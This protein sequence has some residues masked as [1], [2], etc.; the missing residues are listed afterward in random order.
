MKKLKNLTFACL[1]ILGL[2]ACAGDDK[3]S[4]NNPPITDN[5]ETIT[6]K[7]IG[8]IGEETVNTITFTNPHAVEADLDATI[9]QY[10]MED[11]VVFDTASSTCD[12][13]VNLYGN[14]E[15]R[16]KLAAGASCEIKYTY[17][18]TELN[19]KLLW[20]DVDYIQSFETVCPTPD[21]VPT[22]EKL[23]NAKKYVQMRVF[24]YA[25]NSN[26]EKSPSINNVDMGTAPYNLDDKILT[27]LEPQT[28]Q[29][30]FAKDDVYQINDSYSYHLESDGVNCTIEGNTLT[31]LTNEA[32]TITVKKNTEGTLYNGSQLIIFSPKDNT[33]PSYNVLMEVNSD[34]SYEK[35]VDSFTP[36]YIINDSSIPSY[37]IDYLMEDKELYVGI[38]ENGVSISKY[39][40]SGP[41]KAKFKVVPTKDNGCNVIA[42]T[43]TIPASQT[44]CYYTVELADKSQKGDFT[45]IL[46]IGTDQYNING[47]V[48][49]INSRLAN[50]CKSENK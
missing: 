2:A 43:I 8:K 18:P 50:A 1:L 37:I 41:D 19:T 20:I 35:I 42:N 48:D 49:S 23:M 7:F 32:C 17:K 3:S 16:S 14:Y 33:K 31:A 34:I 11:S 38:L 29:I 22:V 9:H 27:D 36:S 15:V 30:P 45:A 44:S 12:E 39:T 24:N 10:T 26:N 28:F 21:T 5:S 46:D 13:F 6:F 25:V 47:I 40:I 4:S